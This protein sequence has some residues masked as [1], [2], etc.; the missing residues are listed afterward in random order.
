M[1]EIREDMITG[2]MVLIA[3]ERS[4]RPQDFKYANE[5]SKG[6]SG[7]V[8][9][10]GNETET[11]PE[12]FALRP[13]GGLPDSPGWIVRAFPN[14]FPAVTAEGNPD[15]HYIGGKKVSNAVGAHEVIVDTPNHYETFGQLSDIHA[16]QVMETIVSR[17]RYFS[18][19]PQI[20]YIQIFKNSGAAAGA[21]LEHSHWQL[22]T[23]PLVPETVAREI[24]VTE[25]F[26]ENNGECAYCR[27][28]SEEIKDGSRI[29][30][31]TKD[32]VVLTP[33]ASRF[34]YET[35]I[36]PT[37]HEPFLEKLNIDEIK[38]L[39]RILKRSIRKLERTLCRPPYNLIIHACPTGIQCHGN[40]WHIKIM[41]RIST[42]AGFE[43]GS[44]IHINP[45]SPEAA[46]D[47]LREAEP[48]ICNDSRM[49]GVKP[50]IERKKLKILYV[51]SEVSPF[52]K[53]GGLADVAG[54][55]PHS[56]AM[57]G[58]DV[59]VVMPRYKMI[60][61]QLNT[62]YDF[63][64]TISGRKEAA[65]I[66]EHRI[67]LD[68]NDSNM[69]LP[70][71]FVDNY[72]YFDRD[73]LYCY[74][75]EVERFAF[76]CRAVIEMLP[77]IGFQPD[78]IHCN[79]WQ[80][81]PIPILL[82]EQYSENNFYR[83][84]AVLFT[85]HNMHYQGNYPKDCLRLLGLDDKYY[86]A[87]SLEFYGDISFLKAGLV[88]SDIINTVSRTYAKE[89]QTP[90]YGERMDGLLRKRSGDLFGIVNG[91]DYEEFDPAKDSHLVQ[92]YD[93][94]SVELKRKNKY[95][96]QKAMKLPQGD[97]PLIALVSRLVDQKGLDLL[98]EIYDR[99]IADD[100][101]VVV[102]GAGD[103][104]YESFFKE[105]AGKY[106]D[107]TAVHIGF[108]ASLA[109]QI[110]AGADMFLMP[111]R[112]EPCGLGQLISLRY[113]SIPIVRATGG[114]ADTIMDYNHGERTGNGFVFANYRSEELL[115]A[116]HRALDIYRR[117]PELW[118]EL[119]R[120]AMSEDFSWSAS[121]LE[122]VRLYFVA[123]AKKSD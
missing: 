13:G 39:G 115:D 116:V 85:V 19:L 9:C 103:Q 105:M 22:I 97:Q 118:M 95:F 83:N 61:Q 6:S 58:H 60:S 30:E 71:Y 17:Y 121:A 68:N 114:L 100:I 26:W 23:L 62:I 46:A 21:S 110:Y 40:H 36:I 67:S 43:I 4:K 104:Y 11:P 98:A 123:L 35:W 53:T 50:M 8:F 51:A 27:M 10:Y 41:P 48:Y 81:G 65:I 75:D 55:L 20:K 54:S 33:F 87:E 117:R 37:R 52:A 84:T 89:I 88:Y 72:N 77:G 25:R 92:N 3:T 79:D 66:R 34:P 74:F 78:I 24:K 108:N 101:Q 28:I 90:D 96:L 91:I 120:K 86:N 5:N 49:N 106:P 82:K 15:C 80:T 119:V 93:Y 16:E 69:I 2:D 59:R 73:N 63:P 47:L 122:Y 31:Q 70:V 45:V 18:E 76:F 1:P 99:L 32:F 64:V 109:Q 29:I 113:G 112:F 56:L 107:K 57:M 102:L 12:I 111:S 38:T 42:V 7:C 94:T 44:G 14:K